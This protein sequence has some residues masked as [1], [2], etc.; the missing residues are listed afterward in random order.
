[1]AGLKRQLQHHSHVDE[2]AKC[3]FHEAEPAL[4]RLRITDADVQVHTGWQQ[5]QQLQQ[6]QQ[7]QD[8][9][10]HQ[11]Q[12]Q[13]QQQHASIEQELPASTAPSRVVCTDQ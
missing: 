12:P 10:Q 4:K 11:Q 9:S 7:Q 13:Q 5:D 3:V 1:M 8:T 6:Q 2:H